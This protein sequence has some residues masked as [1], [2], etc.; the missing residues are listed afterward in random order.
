MSSQGLIVGVV[1]R[2][3][4]SPERTL[5]PPVH[6][7]SEDFSAADHSFLEILDSFGFWCTELS[8]FV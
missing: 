8:E 7:I 5:C 3:L 4:V 6:V 2:A 1:W